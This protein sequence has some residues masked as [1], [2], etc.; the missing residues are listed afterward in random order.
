MSVTHLFFDLDHTLWDY[1]TNSSEALEETFEEFD[2]G[3]CFTT[4]RAFIKSFH[5][6][7]DKLWHEFN[8]GKIERETIRS[9][10]FK[11]ILK[12]R[13]D[14]A[15]NRMAA[16]SSFFIATCSGKSALFPETIP[17][18]DYLFEKYP[19]GIISNGFD[20]IQHHKINN[21]GLKPY[22]QWIITSESAQHR[23]PTAE[24]F[25]YA[26]RLSGAAKEGCVMIG[27]NLKTDVAGARS[28][29][30]QAIWF[31]PNNHEG[32]Y[33]PAIQELKALV[34]LF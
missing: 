2:L 28:S 8:H 7:N 5:F 34:G 3:K 27:D 16:I 13:L 18:L 14:P 31:N 25:R 21:S 11:Q 24:I 22:F 17:T 20:D 32:N 29:G 4:P 10:R 9:E 33:L 6:H 12:G 19:L 26:E 1:Y 23:K 30:W 15:D